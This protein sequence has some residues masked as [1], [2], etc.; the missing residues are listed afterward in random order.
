[1]SQI[2]NFRM[3]AQFGFD[4][5]NRRAVF[6]AKGGAQG[7]VALCQIIQT[8]LKSIQIETADQFKRRGNV[9]TGVVGR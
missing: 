3:Y 1:M 9:V 7:F 8:V 5:L 2:D 6:I 4:N